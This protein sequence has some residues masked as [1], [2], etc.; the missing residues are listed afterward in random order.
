MNVAGTSRIGAIASATVHVGTSSI[1]G[2][3]DD[4]AR[5]ATTSFHADV[6]RVGDD[7]VV[8]SIRSLGTR[9]VSLSILAD[10]DTATGKLVKVL[11]R[12]AGNAWDELGA[13][14]LKQHG[15]SASRDGGIEAFVGTDIADEDAARRIELGVTYGG[16]AA[17]ATGAMHAASGAGLAAAIDAAAATGVVANDPRTGARFAT[18][19]V[20]LRIDDH[21]GRLRIM[22]KA[23]DDKALAERIAASV[24]GAK[25]DEP[26]ELL[27]HEIPKAQRRLLKDAGVVVRK[28]NEQ[29]AEQ[30]KTA[31][32]GTVIDTNRGA[33]LGSLY[34]KERVL[35]GSSG[36]QSRE[37]GVMLVD[38]AA[39]QA[40]AAYDHI[41]AANA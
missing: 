31:L 2:A 25:L 8:D 21:G 38:D 32:H 6:F 18:E 22:T 26:A 13:D 37:V 34:L 24:R 40:R 4:L 15:K 23:F 19:A 3:V 5:H 9:D 20:E 30:A 11:R 1:R 14:P 28:L 33:F 17:A 36:R 12:Q 35:H 41:A 16:E 27:T 29:D 7:A 39:A 10:T